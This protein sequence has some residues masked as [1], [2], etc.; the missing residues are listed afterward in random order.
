MAAAAAQYSMFIVIVLF[1][2]INIAWPP[3]GR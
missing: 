1:I 3:K 2:L